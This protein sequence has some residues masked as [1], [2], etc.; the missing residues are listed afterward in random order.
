M[1]LSIFKLY[2]EVFL[3][4]ARGGAAK[5]K[6]EE[7]ASS[8]RLTENA[9]TAS[10]QEERSARSRMNLEKEGMFLT[11]LGALFR[12]RAAYFRRDKKAWICTTVV[13][14]LFVLVGFLIY[15]FTGAARDLEP[16]ALNLNLYNPGL[17]STMG[18]PQNPIAYNTP[19]S[20]PYRCQPGNC[21][22]GFGDITEDLTK[23]EYFFC[24][25]QG[26][27]SGEPECTISESANIMES[28]E[29][30]SGAST[31]PASVSHVLQ[32]SVSL[33]LTK[34]N[35]SASQYGAIWFTHDFTSTLSTDGAPLYNDTVVEQCNA[36]P[37]AYTTN[38]T[39][40]RLGGIG[41]VI[42]YNYTAL[43]VSP[44]FQSLADEALV[45]R[46]LNTDNFTAQVTI[47]PL[48]TTKAEENIAESDDAFTAWFLVV[49]SFPFI[50]GAFATFIV[51]E[52]ES[53]AKHLQTVAGVEPAAYWLSSWFWDVLNYQFPLWITVILMYAFDVQA[54]TT[55]D[56]G[57]NSGVICL[58]ILFGPAAVSFTYCTTYMFSSP[59]LC[60]MFV[61]VTGFL[62]GLGGPLANFILIIIGLSPDNPKPHLVDAADITVWCLRLF[63]AFNLG[64]GLFNAIN[65]QVFDII[66]GGNVSAW[67]E[68]I[69]LYE[70]YFLAAESI[71]YL[72]IAIQLDMWSNNPH[73]LSIW[74]TFVHIITFSW[75]CPNKNKDAQDITTAQVEDEDVIAEQERVLAGQA[76]ND[77]I[78]VSELTKKYD[79]GKIAV[80]NMS[81]G[82]APG[83]C[84][85]LLGINGAG[86]SL[87]VCC[88]VGSKKSNLPKL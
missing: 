32:S 44:L 16:V 26:R 69:L 52:R 10:P 73:A 49:L 27:L 19:S 34:N 62:I 67:S 28:L 30:F 63:P 6:K 88:L 65:A 47:A 76:N 58:L 71:V 18:T 21:A 39:C 15:K 53:K 84:F 80:N 3:L 22:Y 5:D 13:P 77:L 42:Q 7:F 85:G 24:G 2:A 25:Y 79:N 11:H 8:H 29:G 38:N 51:T 86:E 56:R 81:L 70:V 41:Y 74:S 36:N 14:S 59:S 57:I 50:A 46:Y 9:A 4:V 12:K 68:P 43:H 87:S 64:K 20:K 78:V 55:S 1:F 60:N 40:N 66:E 48:P 31:V 23:E 54:L 83:E 82:I 33:Y 37:G 17:S 61:I 45:K 72:I 75:F 35:Y